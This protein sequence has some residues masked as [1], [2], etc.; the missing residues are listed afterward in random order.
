VLIVGGQPGYVLLCNVTLWYKNKKQGVFQIFAF[1]TIRLLG[2]S[3]FALVRPH[4][5]AA[6]LPAR[7]VKKIEAEDF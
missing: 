7:Q 2:F 6:S 3:T 4:K 5:K 1:N